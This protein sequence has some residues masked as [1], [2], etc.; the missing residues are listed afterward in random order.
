MPFWFPCFL[1][2][3]SFLL[4]LSL[5]FLII[6]PSAKQHKANFINTRIFLWDITMSSA[7]AFFFVTRGLIHGPGCSFPY[8]SKVFHQEFPSHFSRVLLFFLK[9]RMPFTMLVCDR[10]ISDLVIKS[11]QN[12]YGGKI[13]SKAEAILC[14]HQILWVPPY[15]L[16]SRPQPLFVFRDPMLNW[17]LMIETVIN[18]I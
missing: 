15:Q 14:V 4:C 6:V 3:L 17:P 5:Y 13:L 16:K 18:T 1:F 8:F 9:V 2:Y 10:E 7:K 12:K 11:S